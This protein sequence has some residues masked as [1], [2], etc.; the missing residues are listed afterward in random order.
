MRRVRP[1][2]PE[3]GIESYEC[4]LLTLQQVGE[5]GVLRA[6]H[7]LFVDGDSIGPAALR[8]SATSA[9]RFSSTLNLMQIR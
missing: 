4:A 6:A 8:R 2:V 5:I 9:G 7:A 1:N 3:A